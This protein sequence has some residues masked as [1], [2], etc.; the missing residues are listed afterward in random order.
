MQHG[1]AGSV[2][3]QQLLG[4][5]VPAARFLRSISSSIQARICDKI[6]S[7][8]RRTVC[9]LAPLLCANFYGPKAGKGVTTGCSLRCM[10]LCNIIRGGLV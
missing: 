5:D 6:N 3:V 10:V 8:L 1:I 2:A 9:E 7:R 4:T